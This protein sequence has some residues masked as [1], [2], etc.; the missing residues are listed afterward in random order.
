M[1]AQTLAESSIGQVFNFG[2]FVAGLALLFNNA[3]DLNYRQT[4][5]YSTDG[6]HAVMTLLASLVVCVMSVQTPLEIRDVRPVGAVNENAL[7][8][9]FVVCVLYSS[10]SHVITDPDLLAGSTF[11]LVITPG[12][13]LY[14]ALKLPEVQI[15]PV[16]LVGEYLVTAAESAKIFMLIASMVYAWLY[17]V[18]S[19]PPDWA[20]KRD[21]VF[22]L[23]TGAAIVA[24]LCL[25]ML[26]ADL[27]ADTLSVLLL[28]GLSVYVTLFYEH[29]E[30]ALVT[31]AA[32]AAHTMANA[33]AAG[34][35]S[36]V[37]G[38]SV[39]IFVLTLQ[40]IVAV[41]VQA[42][43]DGW[44]VDDAL[45]IGPAVLFKAGNI[46]SIFALLLAVVAYSADW[47][48]FEFNAGS[49]SDT[50]ISQIS[51]AA[52]RID[53]LMD[54]L[55]DVALILDPCT[56]KAVT[57]PD[58]ELA[59]DDTSLDDAMRNSRR[60]AYHGTMEVQEC[61]DGSDPD[62]PFH[63]IT[64]TSG[65][66]C[67]FLYEN[68]TNAREE[69]SEALSD[70][71]NGLGKTYTDTSDEYFVDETCANAQCIALKVITLAAI[72]LSFLPFVS[73]PTKAVTMAARATNA[74]FRIGRKVTK[75]LPRIVRTK[76]KIGKL[77]ARII[78]LAKPTAST[79][80]PTSNVAVVFL[81]I[82]ILA[83]VS[84]SMLMFRRDI[85]Y[86][87]A[88]YGR[89]NRE[90]VT[91]RLSMLLGL[92]APLAVA[93]IC[94]LLVLHFL[95]TVIE[96]V[97]DELPGDFVEPKMEL[98]AGYVCLEMAY[99]VSLIGVLLTITSVLMSL[100][101]E[102]ALGVTRLGFRYFRAG[103][104]RSLRWARA[105]WA[106]RGAGSLATGADVTAPRGRI[107]RVARRL[108]NWNMDLL[109]GM[110][111]CA[112][113][114]YIITRAFMRDEEYLVVSFGANDE[115]AAANDELL[116]TVLHKERSETMYMDFDDTRCSAV[117]DIVAGLLSAV[118]GLDVITDAMGE[119]ASVLT[120][121]LDN[122]A[123]FVSKLGD[124]VE[125]DMQYI[126]VTG[127]VVSRVALFSLLFAVPIL[128]VCVICA[129]W[130]SS[131]VTNGADKR[132]VGGVATFVLYT[133]V[134]NVLVHTVL[135]SLLTA[136][137]SVDMPFVR[138]NAELGS[139]FYDT[140]LACMFTLLAAVS[141]YV[142]ILTPVT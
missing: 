59:Y 113:A 84:L 107:V 21:K 138:M 15:E 78:R 95:P 19:R 127:E 119:F 9:V 53:G 70:T 63:P 96:E 8:L 35:D 39:A 101:Q 57:A 1:F 7:S 48:D 46:L 33:D 116:E 79:L 122:A 31:V 87:E 85:V 130:V 141:L 104:Q 93:E 124:L 91:R 86:K 140:Q 132:I 20:T 137:F 36:A 66:K 92:Y 75:L 54:Q 133:S 98:G 121:S 37:F 24:N 29:F 69:L 112:P 5:A 68:M 105:R 2:T 65:Y 17:T 123:E 23:L 126:N 47:I 38:L 3:L 142:N 135:G 82:V 136:V 72:P 32:S 45:N 97:L 120:G 6:F 71:A 40:A 111:F 56:R 60:D 62:Y 74:V 94:F 52:G 77:A 110:I 109:S 42:V 50:A 25:G 51:D 41:S 139:A 34:D 76:N 18:L 134:M 30:Y 117:G 13:G 64:S 102:S 108:L 100:A 106:R 89:V 128:N 118:G 99:V 81:P 103:V 67:A 4:S 58:T 90:G 28:I 115:V 114:V 12:E 16:E 129:M 11:D 44:R 49:I 131:L 26:V 55:A 80:K 61:F 27:S 10:L 125:F 88:D 73:G 14:G 83:G 43:A 22:R